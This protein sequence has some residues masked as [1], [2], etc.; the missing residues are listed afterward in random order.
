MRRRTLLK[1]ALAGAALG[2]TFRVAN[3]KVSAGVPLPSAFDEVDFFGLGHAIRDGA[4][5]PVP[6]P[7]EER[8]LVI[9]GGG[10]SGLTALYRLRDLDAVLLEKESEPGG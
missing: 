3:G 6:E 4:R 2:W 7:G 9:V 5:F 8:E 1:A 10:I